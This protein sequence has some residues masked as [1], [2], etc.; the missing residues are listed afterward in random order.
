MKVVMMAGT[1]S[2]EHHK[3]HKKTAGYSVG[4][5]VL[6]RYDHVYGTENL[7]L[8]TIEAAKHHC[9]AIASLSYIHH[10]PAPFR[11]T[12]PASKPTRPGYSEHDSAT[13]SFA[14]ISSEYIRSK[15]LPRLP[16]RYQSKQEM[17]PVFP[18]HR[19]TKYDLS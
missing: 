15:E 7:P 13:K 11:P 2:R 6:G 12:M 10:Q 5:D 9:Q 1:R 3:T 19:P 14:K 16:K 8:V 17:M 4:L 18:T